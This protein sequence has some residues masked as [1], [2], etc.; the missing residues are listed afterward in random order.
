MRGRGVLSFHRRTP[1][2]AYGAVAGTPG[3]PAISAPLLVGAE[4]G[5]VFTLSVVLPVGPTCACADHSSGWPYVPSSR[6][7]AHV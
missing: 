7:H 3:R 5:A 6:E 4:V 2:P 1:T